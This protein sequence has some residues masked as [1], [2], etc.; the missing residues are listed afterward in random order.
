MSEFCCVVC[1]K[2]SLPM[3]SPHHILLQ[4]ALHNETVQRRRFLCSH[5]SGAL[6]GDVLCVG[7]FSREEMTLLLQ[8]VRSCTVVARRMH[9][10][11]P[12][13]MNHVEGYTMKYPPFA[14]FESGQF[15]TIL[16]L[17]ELERAKDDFLM[18]SEFAR[19]LRLGGRVVVVT[20]DR[21]RNAVR[22][23][24][25]E[26]EYNSDELQ[27]LLSCSFRQI[28]RQGVCGNRRVMRYLEYSRH[29]TESLLGFDFLM[30]HRWLPRWIF[31]WVYRFLEQFHLQ[32]ML[33]LHRRLVT[34]ITAE[35]YAC[36]ASDDPAC[37][38]LCFTAFK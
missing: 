5:L 22:N 36:C 4:R 26:R 33:I 18:V 23:P 30:L 21:R 12:S 25:H 7:D 17:F 34:S 16:C 11:D 15:D 19:L 10:F 32:K 3:I 37:M 14:P 9:G 31:K 24:F 2:S 28:E 6:T 38:D 27:N 13:S 8:S 1:V 35:D 29:T 20:S